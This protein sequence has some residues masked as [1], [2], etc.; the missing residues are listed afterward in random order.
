MR[1]ELHTDMKNPKAKARVQ[2]LF[3]SYLTI[4]RS[5][6]LKWLVCENQKVAVAHVLS[7][8]KPLALRER[9]VSYLAFS[10]H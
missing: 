7:A 3:A 2:D 4:L 1:N 8:I 9:L 5:H 6:W 10:Y